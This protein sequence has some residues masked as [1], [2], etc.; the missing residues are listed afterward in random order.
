MK[1]DE[2]IW[3]FGVPVQGAKFLA[4]IHVVLRLLLSFAGLKAC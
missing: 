1:H 3:G 2:N 4:Y